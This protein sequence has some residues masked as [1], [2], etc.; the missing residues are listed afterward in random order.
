M[1][2]CER[3]GN[4]GGGVTCA[5]CGAVL[6]ADTGETLVQEWVDRPGAGASWESPPTLVGPAVSGWGDPVRQPP[7]ASGGQSQQTPAWPA[8][9]TLQPAPAWTPSPQ[10]RRPVLPIVAG[11]LAVALVGL[12]VWQLPGVIGRSQAAAPTSAKPATVTV[13]APGA[14]TPAT[15][16]QATQAPAPPQLHGSFGGLARQAG[17]VK[18]RVWSV[19]FDFAG[20]AGTVT[21]RESAT[22]PVY[23]AGTLTQRADG[24]WLEHI[25]VGGCDD[26]GTW[27]FAGSGPLRGAYTDPDGTY[28]V[29][30]EF[31]KLG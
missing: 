25:T 7:A 23:C 29:T 6:P 1:A 16:P 22:S 19:R 14:N 11:V 24:S 4:V 10:R 21:Y 31:A 15:I 3:C 17:G 27:S 28:G 13:T 5:L 12:A 8:Q 2:V 18:A 20:T 9:A 26:G 30:G